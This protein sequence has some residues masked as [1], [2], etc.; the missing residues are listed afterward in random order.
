LEHRPDDGNVN[1]QHDGVQDDD[2]VADDGVLDDS[3]EASPEEGAC[4]N[5]TADRNVTIRGILYT[6]VLTS[7][8]HLQTKVRV[9][10]PPRIVTLRSAVYFILWY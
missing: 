10:T 5:T 3:D 2:G 1:T 9:S 8:K 6:M 7:M 4:F